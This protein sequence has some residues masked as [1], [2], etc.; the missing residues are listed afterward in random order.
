MP[1]GD[2]PCGDIAPT[3]GITG[4]PAID[5]SRG[6][7]FVVADELVNGRPAHMFAGLSTASGKIEVAQDV[8]PAG[9][10]PAA[11]LQR[12]GLTLDDGQVVFGMGG[13]DGDC[14]S[15]RGRV[16]GVPEQGGTP[17]MFTVD[18]AADESQGAIWMGGAAPVVDASGDIWVS[19]GNGSVYSYS[20]AYDDSD[21]ILRAVAV[22]DACAVL[23]A[24]HL[25]REQFQ[26]T[27]TC[28]RRRRCCPTG[29]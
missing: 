5:P 14:A 10:D 9:A 7:I 6:E 27:L 11:L 15:Y 22:A 23:R 21:S 8:D 28:R 19:A 25:G 4:T 16:I 2:L 1:S 17:T 13:N 29:R 24:R 3:V 26:A 12:T 18:A 20:H